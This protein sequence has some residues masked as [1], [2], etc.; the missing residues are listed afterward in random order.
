ML[1]TNGVPNDVINNF[2]SLS[3]ICFMPVLNFG[4]YPLL[5]KLNI[6]YGP[7]ARITTGLAMSTVGGIGYTVLNYYAYQQS[8]C[9]NMGSSDCEIGTGVAPISIWFAAIP[10]ALGGISELFVNV[11]AYGIAYSR[12]PVNMRGLVSA[13]NLFSTA[14]AYIIGLACSSVIKDPYLTWDFG[15]VAIA[16]GIL[17]VI[18]Y[19]TFRHIDQEEY[20]LSTNTDYNLDM[21]GTIAVVGENEKNK[22]SNEPIPIAENEEMMISPKQ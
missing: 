15:G 3:I 9:G 7:V 14:M 12:A 10:F 5:R 2:N 11:P 20:V 17:T 16:G 8:P 13:I 1:T 4:L 21:T 18:F 22:S 19:F 6:H